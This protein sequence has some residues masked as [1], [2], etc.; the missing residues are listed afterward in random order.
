MKRPD[1]CAPLK[2]HHREKTARGESV[3]ASHAEADLLVAD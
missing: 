3:V 1:R 2:P